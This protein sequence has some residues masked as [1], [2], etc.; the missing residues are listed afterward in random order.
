MRYHQPKRVFADADAK[1]A[2]R[3]YLLGSDEVAS[4]KVTVKHL[5]SGEQ[6]EDELA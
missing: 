6:H 4:G 1:N 3:V 2:D 5:A